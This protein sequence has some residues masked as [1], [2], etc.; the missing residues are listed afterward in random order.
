[1]NGARD[2]FLPSA[3]LSQ[4]EHRGITRSNRLNLCQDVLQRRALTDNFRKILG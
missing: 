2:Q 3:G 1:M 4:D